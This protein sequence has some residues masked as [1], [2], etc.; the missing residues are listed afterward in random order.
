MEI[1]VTGCFAV[2][3]L[4][5]LPQDWPSAKGRLPGLAAGGRPPRSFIPIVRQTNWQF[6][7]SSCART[8]VWT[9]PDGRPADVIFPQDVQS[10]NP[11]P[12]NTDSSSDM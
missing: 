12:P 5:A 6:V 8:F 11:A 4:C 2:G 9:R 1:D 10:D 3:W 7:G